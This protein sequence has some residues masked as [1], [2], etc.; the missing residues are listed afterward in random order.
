MHDNCFFRGWEW[1]NKSLFLGRGGLFENG[2]WLNKGFTV[3]NFSS[4]FFWTLC[5]EEQLNNINWITNYG[6]IIFIL[7]EWI[8]G[9][10]A[11][12]T[13]SEA[14]QCQYLDPA[15]KTVSESQILTEGMHVTFDPLP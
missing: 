12:G 13:Q 8:S 14:L 9:T 11:I 7:Q 3:V 2:G 1:L 4:V 6:N 15:A 5:V 10:N